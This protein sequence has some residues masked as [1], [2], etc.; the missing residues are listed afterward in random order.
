MP[1]ALIVVVKA[2]GLFGHHQCARIFWV[3]LMVP[4]HQRHLADG[5]V[6]EV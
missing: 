5:P 4:L 3:E 6:Q 2:G 1:T